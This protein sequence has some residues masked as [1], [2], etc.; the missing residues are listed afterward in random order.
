M[1]EVANVGPGLV[2]KFQFPAGWLGVLV[3]IE[4]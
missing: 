3:V 2:V 1:M 4:I